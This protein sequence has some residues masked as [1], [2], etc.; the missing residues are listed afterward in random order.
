M[1]QSRFWLLLSCLL[2]SSCGT[3][4]YEQRLS[5]TNAFFEYREYLDR[6]LQ[7]GAW[8]GPNTITMRIP[9]GFQLLSPPPIPKDGEAPQPDTRQP[10][11]L[12]LELP[13]LVAAWQGEFPCDVGTGPALLFVCSNHHMFNAPPIEGSNPPEPELFL[14]EFENTLQAAM[15]VQL[16]PGESA[17]VGDNIRYPEVCPREPKYAL[18][19][20]FTAVTFVPPGLL[21][22]VRVPIKAQYYGHYNGKIHVA[23]LVIYPTNVK[24]RMEDKLRT[25]LETFSVSSNV[26]PPIRAGGSSV[27]GTPQPPPGPSF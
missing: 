12:G 4:Q 3:E 11:Y 27:P 18:Q 19:K 24:E 22:D 17:Q 10:T 6:F 15:Q 1:S 5:E 25:A 20:R 2:L 23:I 8:A 13:G 9:K 26:P 7:S 16:P 21:G 14:T